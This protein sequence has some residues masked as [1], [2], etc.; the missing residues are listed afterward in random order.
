MRILVLGSSGFL[1]SYLGFALPRL[2]HEV[3]GV[4]RSAVSFFPKNRVA[5]EP[6]EFS[7]LIL[8]GAYD[9]VVNCVAVASHEVCEANPE[10]AHTVNAVFPGMWARSAQL[11]GAQFV[12]I[13]TDAVFDGAGTHPYA[14]EDIASPPSVYGSSKLAGEKAALEAHEGSLILRTNF[15]GWSHD[16]TS[17][18]L[19]FFVNAFTRDSPIT[20][21][22]DY[23]VASLYMGH[24]SDALS[25]LSERGATG[26]FHTVSRTPLSKFD[27]GHKVAARAGLS[28]ASMAAGF[29]SDASGLAPRGHNLTLSTAKIERE[30]GRPMPSTESGLELAFSEKDALIDYFGGSER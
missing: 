16:Q 1:G 14:E 22:Q 28:A 10:Y 6:E 21:F 19:D 4:S 2:G 7:D 8:S 27:F 15:F 29:V 30:L 12:Q 24:L 23:V 5:S 18:V 11:A 17:G 26:V 3:F 25:E 9:L 13:S 20:G